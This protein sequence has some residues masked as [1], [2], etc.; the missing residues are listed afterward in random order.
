MFA[1][2]AQD[3]GYRVHVF[4]PQCPCPAGAVAD[5]ETCAPFDDLAALEGFA[6]TVDVVTYEFENIPAGP[7]RVVEGLVP[8]MPSSEVLHICQNRAREKAW[9]REN[10]FPHARYAQALEGDIEAAAAEVGIPCVVKTADFGYDGKGQMRIATPQDLAQA[11]AIFR[12]RRCVVEQWVDFEREIS[13]ICARTAHGETRV[14]PASENIHTNHILDISLVPAR[15]PAAVEEAARDLAVRVANK[16]GAVGLV[17]VEM[18]LSSWGEVLVNEIAPRPHNSGHWSIDGCETSQFE[19]HVRA[20]CGLPLGPTGIRRPT[21]MVNIL[22]DAWRQ[23][24]SRLVEPNWDAVLSVPRARL[25]LYG[26]PEPR[27]GRKMGHFTVQGESVADALELALAI[28][29]RL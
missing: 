14:F 18:F 8:L 28:K 9:L 23:V 20:I 25:H 21:V 1:Q 15:I 5:R 17:A 13:V 7:L 22:G 12:G 24:G 27:P 2:A 26:K 29:S 19:Q 3:L 4:E 11:S 16:L 6:R 10:G